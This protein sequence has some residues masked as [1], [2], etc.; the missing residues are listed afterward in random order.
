MLNPL[1]VEKCFEH[2][3]ACLHCLRGEEGRDTLIICFGVG[4]LDMQHPFSPMDDQ[5]YH[6][7]RLGFS[8][9]WHL[10]CSVCSCTLGFE[11]QAMACP[12][13]RGSVGADIGIVSVPSNHIRALEG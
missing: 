7:D 9:Q 5:D 13:V 12:S 11:D 6:V 2:H 1:L 8:F 10:P 4:R 3:Q